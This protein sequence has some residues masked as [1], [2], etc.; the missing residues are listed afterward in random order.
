MVVLEAG[1]AVSL[2]EMPLRKSENLAGP[3]SSIF[4]RHRR[5]QGVPLRILVPE[6]AAVELLRRGRVLLL[7]D[8]EFSTVLAPPGSYWPNYPVKK[9]RS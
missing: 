8:G 6:P 7:V 9:V 5:N 2:W 4:C 1:L 3:S